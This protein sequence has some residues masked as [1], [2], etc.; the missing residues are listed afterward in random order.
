LQVHAPF[1]VR[2]DLTEFNGLSTLVGEMSQLRAAEGA[3][4]NVYYYGL[5]D[6]CGEC[7]GAGGGILS[8]CTVGLA[9]DITGSDMNDAFARAAAGQLNSSADDTFVHEIGHV[10]GRRHIECDGGRHAGGGHRPELP[11]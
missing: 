2:Y 9:F 10:Q 8:G 4:P 7:I 3:D 1:E 6:N 5:F 11:V